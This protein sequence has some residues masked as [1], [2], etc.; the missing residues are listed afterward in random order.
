MDYER[1]HFP[2]T[3]SASSDTQDF[4][5]DLSLFCDMCGEEI[6]FGDE[7]IEIFMGVSGYGQK[8]RRPMVVESKVFD[9]PLASLHPWCVAAFARRHIMDEQLG[10]EVYCSA[11]ES[12]LGDN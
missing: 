10:D 11:C 3:Q 6:E 1:G 4:D 2:G 12:K 8:S 9:H 5:I 7:A